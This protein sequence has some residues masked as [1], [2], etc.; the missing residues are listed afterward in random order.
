MLTLVEM[1]HTASHEK[2]EQIKHFSSSDSQSR[3]VLDY[4]LNGRSKYA[5][6]VPEQICLHH[7]VRGHFSEA[8]GKIIVAYQ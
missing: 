7:A 3:R 6:D 4:T 1:V 8:D 2:W 5:K